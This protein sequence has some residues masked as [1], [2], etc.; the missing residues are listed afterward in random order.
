[1]ACPRRVVRYVINQGSTIKNVGD[2]L[3]RHDGTMVLTLRS[4]YFSSLLEWCIPNDSEKKG[5][6]DEFNKCSRRRWI[7]GEGTSRGR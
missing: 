3:S 2:L 4:D 1:M 7:S 5:R 6:V